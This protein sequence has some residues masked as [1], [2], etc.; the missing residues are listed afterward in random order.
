M[1]VVAARVYQDKIVVAADS[2]LVKGWSKRTGNFAKLEFINEMIVGGCGTAQE[3]GLMWRYMQTHRPESPTEKDVLAFLAEFSQWKK[4]LTG[5][6]DLENQFIMAYK[7]H[8]FE[9]EPM[10]VFEIKDYTAI[11]AG[12]DFANAAL[13][14]GHSPEEAVKV[15]CD[16]SCYVAEP[17]I[18][19]EM[20]RVEERK[21]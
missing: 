15:A 1:S 14:L 19:Y 4:E 2:I 13:Y 16:L 21:E 8:L 3:C 17:V 11:G 12:E 18:R 20:K 5:N 7:G 6:A 9:I 10:F